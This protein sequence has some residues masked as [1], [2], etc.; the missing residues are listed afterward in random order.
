[1]TKQ[2]KKKSKIKVYLQYPWKFPDSPYYKYLIDHPPEGIEYLNVKK[3]KGVITNKRFFW[4]SNFLKR[5]IRRT[6]KFFNFSIPNAHKSPKGNYDLIHCAHCLSKNKNKPWI[7]DFEL[8]WQIYLGKKTEKTRKKVLKIL[9]RKNCK[10]II[11]WTQAISNKIIEEF[12]E[13]K[14]K[15]EVIYPAVPFPNIKKKKHRGINLFFVSRYFETKGG[16]ETLEV[17]DYLTKK[18]P[19]VNGIMVS[20][21]PKDLLKKYSQNKKIKFY[22][23]MSQREMFEKV[24]SISDIL[25]LPSYIGAGS[26][27]NFEAMSFGIPIITVDN[28]D[29][30]EILEEGKTG[31]IASRPFSKSG[32]FELSP[33]QRKILIKELI[34]KTESLINNKKLLGEMSRNCMEEIKNGK[35]S[36]KERNRKLKKIYEKIV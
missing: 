24:Y 1:M 13:I 27:V 12:P 19:N 35:F 32:K 28:Y 22:G 23:L 15:I 18:Y 34:E 26:F 31:L 8:E 11:A 16:S 25:I 4:F 2:N 14:E 6:F 7:A 3:Q 10:K 5:S 17:F 36:I 29:R 30:K 21:V 9:L 20:E 33:A